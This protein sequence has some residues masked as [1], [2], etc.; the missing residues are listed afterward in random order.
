MRAH[1]ATIRDLHA[2]VLS[3]LALLNPHL[4][5]RAGCT[6]PCGDRNILSASEWTLASLARFVEMTRTWAVLTEVASASANRDLA[7]RMW[8]ILSGEDNFP[9]PAY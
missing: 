5:Y 1:E 6:E 3:N 9:S 2:R 8:Q 4:L 7:I